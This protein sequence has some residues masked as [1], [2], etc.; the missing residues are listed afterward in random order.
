M[1]FVVSTF[2]HDLTSA[3]LDSA[4]RELTASGVHEQDM[5]VATVPGSFELPLVARRF[6]RRADID[7]VICLGAGGLAFVDI[8]GFTQANPLDRFEVVAYFPTTDEIG[9]APDGSPTETISIGHS[10]GTVASDKYLYVADG[11][12]GVSAWKL[13]DDQGYPTDD[14]HLVANTVQDEYPV[15][16]GETTVYPATHAYGVVWEPENQSVLTLCQGVGLRRLP[17]AGVESDLG[18]VGAPLLIAPAPEDIFEHNGAAGKIHETPKQDHAYDVAYE[19]GLAYVADGGNGLTIYDLTKDPTDLDSGFF[20]SNLGGA[21]KERPLL[22][23][24]TGIALWTDELVGF[25]YAFMAAGPYGVGVV[26]V[27]DPLE[28]ILIKTFEPVKLED[29]KVGKADG[30]C[31]DVF[32]MGAYAYFTYDSFGVL[33]Y[34][35]A[36]LIEPVPDGIPPTKIWKNQAGVLQYDY[37]PLALGEFRLREE[38]GYEDWGGGALNM[39][40]TEIGGEPVLYVAYGVAGVVKLTWSDPANPILVDVVPTLGECTAI[41]LSNGRLYAS[42]GGGGLVFFK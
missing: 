18:A 21:T 39:N 17:V 34:S 26:N 23:R 3:M 32:V 10:Q 15:T 41:A 35:I 13:L 37:R 24:S 1:A 20:V 14:I 31:V 5:P 33:C 9:A 16:V 2:H 28:P 11:P 25:R 6:A 7:A 30:R 19:D 12:H 8:L 36:D 42:D 40:H 22:G 38:P 4:R 27:T 29:E